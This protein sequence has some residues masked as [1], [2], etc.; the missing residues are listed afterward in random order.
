MEIFEKEYKK[1]KLSEISRV[2]SGTFFEI[3][4][5][6]KRLKHA[7]VPFFE[8]VDC[9]MAVISN[10]SFDKDF[11][12][13]TG[14][15]LIYDLNNLGLMT[16]RYGHSY[17]DVEE[18]LKIKLK[19]KGFFKPQD[20]YIL[21]G[22]MVNYWHW[23]NN[24]LP[25]IFIAKEYFKEQFKDVKLIF[26]DNIREIQLDQLRLIG[27]N[28]CQI[29]RSSVFQG[30]TFDKLY[31]PSFFDNF[32]YSP[33]V[34]ENY[35]YLF[36]KSLVNNNINQL[37]KS[38]NIYLSRQRSRARRV[39]NQQELDELLIKFNFKT[40]YAEE[41]TAIEQFSVFNNARIIISPH[42]AGLANL[43][44]VKPNAKVF[45]LEY[46]KKMTEMRT[47]ALANYLDP[48]VLICSQVDNGCSESRLFDLEVPCDELEEKLRS[49][50]ENGSL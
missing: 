23:I 12:V 40:I 44:F 19:Y 22:G 28:D 37:V 14:D 45:I 38:D 33:K 16:R 11:L 43:N 41:L 8:N 32:H 20:K 25:R 36:N 30:V 2:D 17:W 1:I 6:A 9:G 3:N 31:V 39:S 24:Y 15:K 7:V 50:I 47:I 26:H 10:A 18:N 13:T 46:K 34:A 42:G 48:E 4:K 27:V 49:Y 29:V 5:Y 21:I 35:R